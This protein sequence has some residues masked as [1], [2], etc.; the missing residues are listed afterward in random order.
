MASGLLV[1]ATKHH[2]GIIDTPIS[3]LSEIALVARLYFDREA[4]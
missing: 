2:L 3:S 4:T 1:F